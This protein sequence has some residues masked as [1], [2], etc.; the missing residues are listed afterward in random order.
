M[1]ATPEELLK[2]D[3]PRSFRGFDENATA[4]LIERAAAALSEALAERDALQAK[5]AELEQNGASPATAVGGHSRA[6]LE[7]VGS[8]LLTAHRAAER[9]LADAKQEADALTEAGTAEVQELARR[10]EQEIALRRSEAERRIEELQAQETQLLEAIAL[11]C[12]ELATFV[13]QAFDQLL[14]GPG[15]DQTVESAL[16]ERV[17]QVTNGPPAP[18]WGRVGDPAAPSPGP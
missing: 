16:Q 17:G 10:A 12:Q 14:G 3:L 8:A 5:V 1:A 13:R 7:Q 18:Q 2:A 11:R 4:D 15:H 9:L 6:E